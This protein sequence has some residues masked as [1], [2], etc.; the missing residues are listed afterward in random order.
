MRAP[1]SALY[2]FAALSIPQV[3]IRSPSG[4]HATPSTAIQSPL[5]DWEKVRNSPD[6]AFQISIAQ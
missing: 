6:T 2:T 4:D 3:A 1:V 5:D